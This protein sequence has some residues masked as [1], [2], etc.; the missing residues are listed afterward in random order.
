MDPLT[1]KLALVP[2][3]PIAPDLPVL[4]EVAAN[5]NEQVVEPVAIP[6]EGGAQL[7]TD[8]ATFDAL[9]HRDDVP[10]AAGVQ[11]VKFLIARI[12]GREPALYFINS[13][14]YPYHYYFA[15]DVLAVG[16]SN[17]DF[18][19][20]TY[21]SDQRKFIA[22]TIIAHD[23][24]SDAT[25]PNGLYAVE[26]WPTDPVS[27]ALAIRSWS[28]ISTGMP[29]AGG[30]VVH[31]PSGAAQE[32]LFRTHRHE[33]AAAGVPV[34][35]SDQLFA[36]MTFSSLNL[37]IGFGVL[38]VIDAADPRPPG[39]RDIAIFKTLPNDLP[40]VGGVLSE[41]PQTP[42]SHVNLRAKQN[43]T[44]N[45]YLRNAT[46]DPRVVANLGKIVR[47]TVAEDGLVI[48]PATAQEMDDFFEA[49]RP[50]EPQIPPRDL[51]FET[52]LA[53][54]DAG[55]H[56]VSKIGAKAAN[57][58]ELR[59]L[60]GKD[61]VPNGFG[62]PF[63]FYNKFMESNGL[64][65][66]IARRISDPA[67]KADPVEREVVLARIRKDIRQAA[68]PQSLCKAL[69]EM[70]QTLAPDQ[71]IRCRSS[72]NSEDLEGFNGAGL[73]DSYTHR[74]DEGRI[75]NT[76]R[77]VWASLWNFRA[78]EE[79][80]FYRI[81]HFSAAMAVL[82]HPNFDDEVAN[83]VALTKNVY[84]PNFE[85]FY[86][87]VQVGEALVTNPGADAVSEELLV[88]EDANVEGQSEYETIYIR[89][90]TLVKEGEEVLEK[91]QVAELTLS[92]KAIQDHFRKVYAADTNPSFAMDVEFKFDSGSKL[93]VKQARPWV[94]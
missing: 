5:S 20:Q 76:V 2:A 40:H 48:Q 21:F 63:F 62:I 46:S 49:Q 90:S 51:S 24:F 44:P 28:L 45:A 94:D 22:G 32:E 34:I 72:T 31:H 7:L 15:R 67:F 52:I 43:N 11:E 54:D 85:G 19:K 25:Y 33:F 68:V 1:P 6:I 58:A 75:V 82:V 86:I 59:K 79:R 78:F 30:T 17:E 89:R 36:N 87:N 77:K 29:F 64:Y 66:R 39:L 4:K 92:L 60:L 61:I 37:G 69:D 57:V 3:L 14:K 74:P 8:R 10:G 93:V 71:A 47:Y 56:D 16:L 27:A 83:G 50:A 84:F 35:L 26:F 55:H 12:D 13:V 18:N 91:S 88:M 65:E 42:L 80:D 53:L 73:Y 70:R 9:S 41:E 81:D 23:N 38:R